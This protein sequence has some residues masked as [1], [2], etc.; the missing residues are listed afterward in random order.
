MNMQKSLGLKFH[1]KRDIEERLAFIRFYVE[2]LKENPDE[3]F[4]EQVKL[5]NSFLK[6]AKDFPLSKEDYLRLKGELKD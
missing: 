4:K 2:K 1:S 3:V 5:I 6:A